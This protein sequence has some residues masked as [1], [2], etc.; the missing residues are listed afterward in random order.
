MKPQKAA[1]GPPGRRPQE[2]PEARRTPQKAAGDFQNT[3]E[4][5]AGPRKLQEAPETSKGSQKAAGSTRKPQ[6]HSE[7]SR[8]PQK[9]AGSPKKGAGGR[10]RPRKPQKAPDGRQEA[11]PRH[12]A[13]AYTLILPYKTHQAT[14]NASFCRTNG[15]KRPKMLYF[16]T[17]GKKEAS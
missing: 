9:A 12:P 5:P 15:T 16:T 7:S 3:A 1:A 4:T 13:H 14:D 17:P 11:S 2:A 10:Q 6:E 8:R